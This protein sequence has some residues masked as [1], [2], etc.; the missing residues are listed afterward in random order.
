MVGSHAFLARDPLPGNRHRP[1]GENSEKIG[2]QVER[3]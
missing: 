1:A 3:P 2:S